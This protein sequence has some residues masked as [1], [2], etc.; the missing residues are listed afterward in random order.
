M[1]GFV[2]LRE[3]IPDYH[4]RVVAPLLLAP[5]SI[6]ARANRSLILE[7]NNRTAAYRRYA[8]PDVRQIT[9]AYRM[10]GHR[11]PAG[12][13]SAA[14]NLPLTG[15]SPTLVNS[16]VPVTSL[17][18]IG[19]LSESWLT[20]AVLLPSG[21][22]VNLFRELFAGRRSASLAIAH[23]IRWQIQHAHPAPNFCV[24]QM[25]QP[26][27]LGIPI[28]SSARLVSVLH[29]EETV[30]LLARGLEVGLNQG[31]V[32][33][34]ACG[35][36]Q[37]LIP[38]RFVLPYATSLGAE[39]IE[40][41]VREP[42]KP[43]VPTIAVPVRV[44]QTSYAISPEGRG[45]SPRIPKT[46]HVAEPFDIASQ[47]AMYVDTESFEHVLGPRGWS[48]SAAYAGDGGGGMTIVP[49]GSNPNRVG[50]T[51]ISVT[52]VPACYYCLLSLVCPY[53]KTARKAFYSAYPFGSDAAMCR[54][55]R[56]VIVSDLWPHF[57]RV[58]DPPGV[59]GAEEPSGGPYWALGITYFQGNQRSFGPSQGSYVITCTLPS[60][61][62]ALCYGSLDWFAR[63]VES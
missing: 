57:R 4:V 13:F 21:Q 56:G 53:F 31:I 32:Y 19:R 11:P 28:P 63:H 18:P 52:E 62:H 2:N 8:I 30:A 54:L 15:S 35:A 41:F 55:H 20:D 7:L 47:V 44:C 16:L 6:D 5:G 38:Y 43:F 58:D 10:N 14:A 48:C 50:S 37:F 46:W 3:R 49:P 9:K 61:E 40:S 34:R 12:E 60:W 22:S 24:R 51:G 39:L 33:D 27:A 1:I 59:K 29:T 25:R 23:Q 36:S 45:K 26:G 17:L 42:P